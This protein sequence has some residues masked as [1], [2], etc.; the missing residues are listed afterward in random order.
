VINVLNRGPI[1]AGVL[2]L[3]YEKQLATANQLP[4]EEQAH[5]ETIFAAERRL[6]LVRVLVIAVNS[7]IYSFLTNKTGTVPWLAYSVIGLACVYGLYVYADEPYRRYPLLLSSY[8]TSLTDAALIIVW[9]YATGGTKSP[10][11]LVL[12]VSVLAVSFRYPAKETLFATVVYAAS[13]WILLLWGESEPLPA[14]EIATRISYIFLTAALGGTF[15]REIY[16]QTADKIRLQQELHEKERKKRKEAQASL[17]ELRRIQ[18]DLRSAIKARDDF[19][20]VAGHELKTPLAALQLQVQGLE[21]AIEKGLGPDGLKKLQARLERATETVRG[22][23]QLI[24]ELLDVSRMTSGKL[25][26]EKQQLDLSELLKGVVAKYSETALKVGCRLELQSPAAIVGYWDRMRLEQVVANLLSNAI[27]YGQEKPVEIVVFEEDGKAIIKVSDRGIGIALD[28]Q[29]RIFERFERA[30][31]EREFG[32]LG[33]GLWIARCI[34]EASGGK[35]RVDSIPMQGATFTVTLPIS[36]TQ[37]GD[38]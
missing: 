5:S 37:A 10:F 34:V 33:L 35:I 7:L 14:N 21:L 38:P 20:S 22:L 29:M 26:L 16:L 36:N 1:P 18:A 2:L 30:V 24:D 17:E 9:L 11:Y 6:T 28:N 3:S 32:G 12:Y 25:K 13:Y 23:G 31:S 15:S 19:L 8:F 4:V 27:K